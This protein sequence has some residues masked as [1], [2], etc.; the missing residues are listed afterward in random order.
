MLGVHI[1]SI[2]HEAFN[3]L[4]LDERKIENCLKLATVSFLNSIFLSN[5]KHRLVLY[6]AIIA[7]Y[8]T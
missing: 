1:Y 6:K 2:N 8:C 7:T 4:D 3:T 5:L